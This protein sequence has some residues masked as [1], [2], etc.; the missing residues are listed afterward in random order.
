MLT[1]PSLCTQVHPAWNVLPTYLLVPSSSSFR[2]LLGWPF[3][4]TLFKTA[5]PLPLIIL[6]LVCFYLLE[7]KF[8]GDAEVFPVV[9]IIQHSCWHML[10]TQR[11]GLSTNVSWTCNSQHRISDGAHM[12]QGVL[13][14]KQMGLSQ[15]YQG[16]GC[17]PVVPRNAYR[18]FK[19]QQ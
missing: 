6:L 15:K 2:S 13:S 7:Y 1:H 16:R 3:L 8:H 19:I 5:T 12:L 11:V 14:P 17:S 4:T 18:V 10:G 9:F